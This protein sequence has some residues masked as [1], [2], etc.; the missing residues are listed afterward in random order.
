L[1]EGLGKGDLIVWVLGS[2]EE[3]K[4]LVE[5][6][7]FVLMKDRGGFMNIGGGELVEDEVL[8]GGVEEN[9][10]GDGYVDVLYEEGL[11]ESDRL[12]RMENVRVSG[13]I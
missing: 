12:W 10:M 6:K 1:R 9:K 5:L 4:D 8:L 11:K 13:D 7:D 2:R 3:R